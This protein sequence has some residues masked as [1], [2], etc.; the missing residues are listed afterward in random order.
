MNKELRKVLDDLEIKENNDKHELPGNTDEILNDLFTYFGTIFTPYTEDN[1]IDPKGWHK[2][3]LN[4]D[5]ED[6]QE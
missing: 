2:D 5:E 3:N 4:K 6:E 1:D